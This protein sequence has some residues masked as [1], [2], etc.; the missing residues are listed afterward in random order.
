MEQEFTEQFY[1]LFESKKYIS[2]LNNES[3]NVDLN[4]LPEEVNESLA[5]GYIRNKFQKQI[6]GCLREIIE[7]LPVPV[8]TYYGAP[9]KPIR[10]I[11][12]DDIGKLRTVNGIIVSVIQPKSFIR[13][14]CFFCPDCRELM[15][16]PQYSAR[17]TTPTSLSTLL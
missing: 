1:Q 2:Q 13:N 9:R 15:Y 4:D 17:L 5:E 8:I 14:A 10:E 11:S 16:E 3:V 7:P 12:S 6:R